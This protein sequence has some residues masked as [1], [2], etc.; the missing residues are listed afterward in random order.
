[1]IHRALLVFLIVI[2]VG[3]AAWWA[4]S[5]AGAIWVA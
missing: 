4:L 1:M 3:I 5:G 2:N